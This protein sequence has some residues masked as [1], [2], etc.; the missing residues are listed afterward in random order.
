[1]TTRPDVNITQ[2]C[3]PISTMTTLKAN[4]RSLQPNAKESNLKT[5]ENKRVISNTQVWQKNHHCQKVAEHI[6][7]NN[8]NP[9]DKSHR[10]IP[11]AKTH[12]RGTQAEKK[13]SNK[14]TAD[15][16]K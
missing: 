3:A 9:P 7:L 11:D 4:K 15:D 2:P 1:M 12:P 16:K 13:N 10:K 6:K 8:Q 14:D 5:R